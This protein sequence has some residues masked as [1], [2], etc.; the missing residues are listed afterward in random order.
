MNRSDLGLDLD[1]LR[2]LIVRPTLKDIDLYSLAAENLVLGTAI[3]E[4]RLK[5]I[6]QYGKGPALG[7]WQMEPFTHNDIWRT[8][9]TGQYLGARIA[10]LVSPN[11]AR[12]AAENMVWNLKYAAAMCR[13]HYLRVRS[14]LPAP[15]DALGMARYWKDFYNT[16]LGK[17]TVE[18]ALPAFQLAVSSVDEHDY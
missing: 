14:P 3:T 16:R 10:R 17:G 4:S 1:Q 15:N 8:H 18:K 11:G 6:K 12:P 2:E 13:V 9:L 5:A 7:L